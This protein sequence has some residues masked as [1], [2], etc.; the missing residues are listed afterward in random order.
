[1]VSCAT[2]MACTCIGPVLE[3]LAREE[4]VCWQATRE[5]S[6]PNRLSESLRKTGRKTLNFN[7]GRSCSEV[8][9]KVC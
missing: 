1:M 2:V 4:R 8:N 7:L 6:H 9:A 5:V 3:V